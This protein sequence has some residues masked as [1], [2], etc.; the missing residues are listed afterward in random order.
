MAGFGFSEAQEMFRREVRRFVDTELMP[1]SKEL[2]KTETGV[3]WDIIR[4]MGELGYLGIT[5]PEKYGG[6]A[7]DWV[8]WGIAAEELGKA[9][10]FAALVSLVG[11]LAQFW[12]GSTAEEFKQEWIPA[13]VKGEK[14]GTWAL[15]EPDTGSD[16]AA[17]KTSAVRDGDDYIINGEKMPIT[18]GMGADAAMTMTKTDPTAGAKGVTNFWLPLDLPG[19]TRSPLKHTGWKPHVAAALTFENVRVPARYRLGEEGQGFS[20][21]LGV[22]DFA[23][24]GLALMG[25]G[26]AQVSLEETMNYVQQRQAFGQP[27]GRFEGVSFKIAEH[28]TLIEAARLLCYRT[29]YLSDQGMSHRKETAMCKWWGPRVAFDA[30]HDCILLHGHIGYSEEY[31]LEQRLRDCLGLEFTDGTAEIMKTIIARDLMGNVARPY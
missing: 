31:P 27:I 22:T 11:G 3:R 28:A 7:S 24:V 8:T 17:I 10:H 15:T 9:S 12:L 23:R 5:V 1:I 18:L 20:V 4:R 25:L 14:I 30:V 29:L 6:Q 21:G 19:I 26:T 16:A 2:N 13:L